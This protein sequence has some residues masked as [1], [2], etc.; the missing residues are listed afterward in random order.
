MNDPDYTDP[1]QNEL[2]PTGRVDLDPL[3]DPAQNE[4]IPDL[5]ELAPAP[6]SLSVDELEREISDFISRSNAAD[7]ERIRALFKG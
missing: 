1:A 6:R 5:A 4:L 7:Y 3:Q 2:I